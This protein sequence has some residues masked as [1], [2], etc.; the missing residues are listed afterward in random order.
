LKT[1]KKIQKVTKFKNTLL[2]SQIQ[3]KKQLLLWLT[4]RELSLEVLLFLQT[5]FQKDEDRCSDQTQASVGFEVTAR[6]KNNKEIQPKKEIKIQLAAEKKLLE[7]SDD[8]KTCLGTQQQKEEEWKC[9]SGLKKINK[10]KLSSKDS[11]SKVKFVGSSK[12]Q[13]VKGTTKHFS[14]FAVLLLG[15]YQVNGCRPTLW[16]AHVI[17]TASVLGSAVLIIIVGYLWVRNREKKKLEQLSKK[18]S[19]ELES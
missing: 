11:S 3:I 9:S 5:P 18:L 15:A 19:K 12:Y 6:D 14:T 10:P 7:H 8:E 2:K 4:T 16:I 1:N 13:Y 17:V